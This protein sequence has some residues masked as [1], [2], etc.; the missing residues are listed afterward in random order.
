MPYLQFLNYLVVRVQS[1]KL[2]SSK[3][4]AFLMV[5]VLQQVKGVKD[6]TSC[7]AHR[8][9]TLMTRLSCATM[10]ASLS[11]SARDTLICGAISRNMVTALAFQ[12]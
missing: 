12:L 8:A 10:C 7:H 6:L 9:P 1:L 4:C 11:W 2:Y 3:V 5:F